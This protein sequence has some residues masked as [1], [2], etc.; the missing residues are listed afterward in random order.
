MPTLADDCFAP[1]ERLM[2]F[3]DALEI[4]AQRI[5]PVTG[6]ET[7]S[8][9]SGL[10][11]T[12]ARDL[13]ADRDVPPSDNTAVDGYAVYFEDLEATGETRLPVGARVAAGHSLARPARLGEAI[14][15][16]TG[17]PIPEGPDTVIMEE[18]CRVDS[19]CVVVGSRPKRGAN[20]RR[21][22]EDIRCGAT[23][24]AAGRRLRAQ[25]IGLAA[26]VGAGRLTVFRRLRCAV[27]STGDEIVDPD[28]APADSA[29]A[30]DRI[31][32]S[33]RF[34]IMSLLDGLGCAVT[35]L[36]IVPDTRD[37]VDS[38]L[39]SAASEHDLLITSGGI[40]RGEKD[41]VAAAVQRLGSLYFWRLAV[42]PGRPIALGQVQD[43]TFLG[44]P[45][46]PVAALVTFMRI[47]RPVVLAL[48]GCKEVTPHLFRV[49]AGFSHAGKKTGR[50]EWLRARLVAGADGTLVAHKFP[51]EGS[52]ILTSM[53]EAD[54]LV[55]LDEDTGPVVEGAFVDFLPFN[56]VTG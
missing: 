1:S 53:V 21:A 25:E 17:A 44:L 43:A 40:S 19:D 55:E 39:A 30:G 9:R 47:A 37:A 8:L 4:L 48:G 35:D 50:R 10:G 51:R 3:P 15:V 13:V 27:F 29:G 46:N 41:H 33:N 28:A 54:G 38:A 7:V 45:G 6:I 31:Y 23:I 20:L 26:S 34:A 36:G 18:D 11:R 5:E 12:L 52:G 24:L 14:R 16:F 2:P 56:E 32:D 49:T 42:K 22:G